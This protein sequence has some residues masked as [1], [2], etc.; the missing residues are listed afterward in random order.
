[1]DSLR[2]SILIHKFL[3]WGETLV[4][5]DLTGTQSKH[6]KISLFNLNKILDKFLILKTEHNQLFSFRLI[7]TTFIPDITV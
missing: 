5:L 4:Y 2:F 6:L 3:L 1:M 7:R